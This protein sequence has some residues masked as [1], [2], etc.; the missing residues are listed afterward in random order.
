[1]STIRYSA[2]CAQAIC[3]RAHGILKIWLENRNN[4]LRGDTLKINYLKL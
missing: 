4:W 3:M 2:R 1:M